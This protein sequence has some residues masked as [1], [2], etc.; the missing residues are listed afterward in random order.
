MCEVRQNQFDL[1]ADDDL[2]TDIELLM[3]YRGFI[4]DE[5]FF[6]ALSNGLDVFPHLRGRVVGNSY[7]DLSTE[8]GR[9]ECAKNIEL[10]TIQ[11][12]ER[13]PIVLQAQSF[14]PKK[15]MGD[16][17]AAQVTHC[18]VADLTILG[19]R[20]SHAVVDG[21]GMAL[22]LMHST[23]SIQGTQAPQVVHDRAVVS[24]LEDSYQRE[25][26]YGYAEVSNVAEIDEWAQLTPV[27]FTVSVEAVR[28]HF[29]ASSSRD[30]KMGFAAWLC[31]LLG[32]DFSEVAVWCDVRGLCGVP[33]TYTGNV[34]CY[35]HEFLR[36]VDKTSL[37][38]RLSALTMRSGFQHIMKTFGQLLALE[39]CGQKVS[40]QGIR[41][42]V[43]QLNLVPH[44]VAGTDFGYGLPV[45]A[46]LLS[47]NSSG[48]RLSLTP[49][50][51]RF[52]VE[53]CLPNNMG[54]ILF[55]ECA[56][57]SLSPARLCFDSL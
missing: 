47:R 42:R 49:D 10:A 20:V 37:K 45:H 11:E 1:R 12:W 7:I 38:Q 18:P 26:P 19:L 54:E 56:N 13:M 31:H 55:E 27:Y 4:P 52:L 39:K 44:V 29:S 53:V 24:S 41:N 21:T 14:L 57:A 5:V 2:P 8:F 36:N 28:M 16:S 30:A 33:A 51:S 48:I 50:A 22:F 23:A 6:A 32:S 34:G 3:G 9:F 25:C 40:W 15:R 46:L 35:I 17:F 43:L